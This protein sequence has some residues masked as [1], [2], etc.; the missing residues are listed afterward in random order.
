MNKAL[1][2]FRRK[3]YLKI[4]YQKLRLKIKLLLSWRCFYIED[5]SIPR[6]LVDLI[7][8]KGAFIH[9]TLQICDVIQVM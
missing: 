9:I 7:A 3:I 6:S 5:T 4:L 1:D 2:T 8:Q